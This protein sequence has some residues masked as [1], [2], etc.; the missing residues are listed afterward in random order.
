[1]TYR[2]CKKIILSSGLETK[3]EAED[4]ISIYS[5]KVVSWKKEKLQLQLTITENNK[6]FLEKEDRLNLN[7]I[8]DIIRNEK[9]YIEEAKEQ[10]KH[11]FR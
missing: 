4:F 11:S 2:I 9:R 10:I 6:I 8:P 5:S 7:Q 3:Q 1:M